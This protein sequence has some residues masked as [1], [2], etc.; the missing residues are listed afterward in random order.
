MVVI[1]ELEGLF[2][3]TVV[4]GSIL[5]GS[6]AGCWKPGK[7]AAGT[8]VPGLPYCWEIFGVC[9]ALDEFALYI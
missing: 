7:P 6:V 9:L 5:A 4:P 1:P 2:K 3:K 8:V